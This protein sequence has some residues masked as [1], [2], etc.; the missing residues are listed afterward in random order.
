MLH[1]LVTQHVMPRNRYLDSKVLRRFENKA[2][3]VDLLRTITME[4]ESQAH[5]HLKIEFYPSIRPWL[6]L[7]LKQINRLAKLI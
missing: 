6:Q 1:V 7:Y 3:D 5:P 2:F 4:F